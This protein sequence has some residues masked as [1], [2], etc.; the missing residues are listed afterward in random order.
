MLY[1]ISPF[2]TLTNT[3]LASFIFNPQF[4]T[5]EIHSEIIPEQKD[6]KYIYRS[7]TNYGLIEKIY[8]AN[9]DSTIITIVRDPISQFISGFF[10]DIDCPPINFGTQQEIL[11]TPLNDIIDIFNKVDFLSTETYNIDILFDFYNKIMNF[12]VYDYK[13]NYKYSTEG[14]NY[15]DVK[16]KYDKTVRIIIIR[17]DKISQCIHKIGKMFNIDNMVLYN[18]NT[19]DEKWYKNLYKEFKQTIYSQ[20]RIKNFN[21]FMNLKYVN[22]FYNEEERSKMAN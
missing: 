12:N 20:K 9:E 4:P 17:S 3:V 8:N 6:G 11:D 2:K 22:Y 5:A 10:Q 1:I 15:Y 13:D 7:H 14:Y 21:E 18:A 16:N 19:A